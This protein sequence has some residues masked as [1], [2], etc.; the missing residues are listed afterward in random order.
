[1]ELKAHSFDRPGKADPDIVETYDF[2]EVEFDKSEISTLVE[3]FNLLLGAGA[4]KVNLKFVAHPNGKLTI[5][6]SVTYGE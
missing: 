3:R 6:T 4:D 1:M 5:K 2:L